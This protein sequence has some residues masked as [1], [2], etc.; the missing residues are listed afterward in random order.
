MSHNL[1]VNGL[2][3]GAG[4]GRGGE[5]SCRGRIVRHS[6]PLNRQLTGGNIEQLNVFNW[7]ILVDDFAEEFLKKTVVLVTEVSD[8]STNG[9]SHCLNNKL[10]L[11][12]LIN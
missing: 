10:M 3:K 5:A 8:R 7:K 9:S 12:K 11:I 2:V 6:R 4:G 1:G